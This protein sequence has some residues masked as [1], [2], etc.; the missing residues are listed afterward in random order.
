M[1]FKMIFLGLVNFFELAPQG[2]LVLLPDGRVPPDDIDP[3]HKIDSHNA[4]FY[5]QSEDVENDSRWW[6]SRED[7]VL[8]SRNIREF[9]IETPSHIEISGME[10]R[11]SS[12][13]PFDDSA[14]EQKIIRLRDINQHIRIE[15]HVAKTIAQI[16]L[17]HGMLASRAIG[18]AIVAEHDVPNHSGTV[19]IT[20]IPD[21]GSAKRVL[22]VK[23]GSEIVVANISGVYGAPPPEPEASHFRLYAQ[24]DSDR[25]VDLLKAPKNEDITS[26]NIQLLQS[27]HR[28]IKLIIGDPTM[29]PEG[30][31][32]VTGCCRCLGR[33]EH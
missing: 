17:R 8:A 26:M 18:S 31:C 22:E 23:A 4:G 32:S 16:P 14:F 3:H 1:A 27:A 6:A 9:R 12:N 30:Q 21:D 15:P 25:R 19:T 11:S 24:L 7:E 10:Q 5:I 33:S 13:D 28:Y 29:V 2:R 20:A